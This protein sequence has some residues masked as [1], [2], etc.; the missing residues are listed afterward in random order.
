M[1]QPNNFFCKVVVFWIIFGKSKCYKHLSYCQQNPYYIDF[2]IW[3][4]NWFCNNIFKVFINVMLLPKTC[5]FWNCSSSKSVLCIYNLQRHLP[6][7]IQYIL[8]PWNHEISILWWILLLQHYLTCFD[9]SHMILK[10]IVF[11]M[12]WSNEW[13]YAIRHCILCLPIEITNLWAFKVAPALP[14]GLRYFVKTWY[15]TYK[16]DISTTKMSFLK[17]KGFPDFYWI[18]ELN[19]EAYLSPPVLDV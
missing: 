10:I 7:H 14:G 16:V 5:I 8:L 12:L 19:S 13:L 15:I 11:Y 1:W 3:D 17:I 18:E 4:E 2:S 9:E 6:Y